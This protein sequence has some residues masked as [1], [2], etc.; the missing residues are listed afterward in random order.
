[1]AVKVVKITRPIVPD[2]DA[3]GSWRIETEDS[4]VC[5]PI[6]ADEGLREA[7]G[8]RPYAYFKAEHSLADGWRFLQRVKPR[9]YW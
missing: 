2:P 4:E 8:C 7:L 6:Y 5:E 3:Y 1:M 9:V